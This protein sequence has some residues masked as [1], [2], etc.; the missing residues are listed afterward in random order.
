MVNFWLGQQSGYT[1]FPCFLCLWDNRDDKNHWI[2]KQW[3]IRENMV[4]GS[5]NVIN[6]PL[7]DRDRI[8]F[9]PL[10]IKLGVMKQF[11]KSLDRSGK[12]FSY[13]TRTFPPLSTE[14]NQSRYLRRPQIRRLIKDPNFTGSVTRLE[15]AAWKGFVNIVKG[16][17]SGSRAS[18]NYYA[19]SFQTSGS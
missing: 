14:K 3:S 1:K 8:V 10:H 5:R 7:V 12:C 6:E 4:V 2:E 18:S 11:V 15:A 16:F 13:I 19:D 17:L 9:P